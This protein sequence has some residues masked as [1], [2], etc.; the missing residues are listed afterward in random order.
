M[1]KNISKIQRCDRRGHKG[2]FMGWVSNIW[3]P[4]H[5]SSAEAGSRLTELRINYRNCVDRNQSRAVSIFVVLTGNR[6]RPR[7]L[8]TLTIFPFTVFTPYFSH[9]ISSFINQRLVALSL[10]LTII[11]TSVDNS[12]SDF[13]QVTMCDRIFNLIT[14]GHLLWCGRD[15]KVSEQ[16]SGKCNCVIL[17]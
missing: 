12:W 16:H 2:R 7:R 15:F 13:Q 11:N 5:S 9:L 14:H 8:T 10:S 6:C 3:V 4:G 1:Q 17:C